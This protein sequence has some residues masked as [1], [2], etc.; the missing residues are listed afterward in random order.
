[1]L[2]WRA[3]GGDRTGFCTDGQVTINLRVREK[4]TG[5]AAVRFK[6]RK[7]AREAQYKLG[8][9]ILIV[10]EHAALWNFRGDK[11][12]FPVGPEEKERD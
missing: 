2:G 3:L 9:T 8:N 4:T 7:E 5:I 6:L 1:M 10:R 11:E 12:S